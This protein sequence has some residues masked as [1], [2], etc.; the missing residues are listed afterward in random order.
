MSEESKPT[1]NLSCPLPKSRYERVVMA[2]GGGGSVMARLIDEL[3][4]PA[5]GN[6]WL[7][8]NHDGAVFE[9]NRARMA[10]T[11]DSFV[12]RPLFFP[13]GNIGSLAVH[14]SVNDLAMCGARPLY[15]SVGF[16]L[17]EGLPMET[18]ARVV[19]SMRDAANEAGVSIVTG[20]TKVVEKGR[21]D[22]LYINTSGVGV[23]DHSLR[24]GPSQVQPGDA[25]IVNGDL[26][27]HGIA[28]LSAREGLE[29]ECAPESDSAPLNGL[30]QALIDAGVEVHCLRD[31]TRGGAASALNE[32]ATAS[33]MEITLEERA[34]P[35]REDV[36]GACELLGFDP[37]YVANEGRMIAFV[38]AQQAQRA[39]D[40]MRANPQGEGAALIGETRA[41]KRGSVTLRSLIGVERVLDLLS[42]EQLPRIC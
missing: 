17:E 24:I 5:F 14:G 13:G 41:A 27:R 38:P 21:G 33:G 34:I 40:V 30:T 8:Q 4:R 26:G 18:L 6:A 19:A 1:F 29:F 31:C 20:D 2:H 35:V 10:F 9:T 32:I 15:L 23:I 16:I 36:R 7:D 28:V 3:F 42:G 22:G 25:V 39:L 11:T 37:L 12:V